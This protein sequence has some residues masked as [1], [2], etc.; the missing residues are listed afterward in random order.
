MPL[1][2]TAAGTGGSSDLL[3]RAQFTARI[4]NNSP[5]SSVWEARRQAPIPSSRFACPSSENG[6]FSGLDWLP[7]LAAA[8]GNPNI[9]ER[10]L[11]GV[12]LKGRTY[13]NHLDGY[14]ELDLLLGKGP[15]ARHELFYFG[16]PQLG[17]MRIDDQVPVLSATLW[18]AWGEYDNR[19]AHDCQPAPG[20]I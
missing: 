18:L 10:L 14:N 9:T 12:T 11:K 4:A 19:H 20:P 15:S 6:L 16:G 5:T 17:A 1:L 3:F 13:K 7:T 8:A 2:E